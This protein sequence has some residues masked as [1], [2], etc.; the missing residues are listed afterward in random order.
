MARVRRTEKMRLPTSATDLYH[1][2]SIDRSV[3]ESPLSLAF[4]VEC[5][6]HAAGPAETLADSM[7]E[8]S[9]V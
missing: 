3:L 9:L 8:Q 5:G 7:I 1:E 4:A 6:F 2:H